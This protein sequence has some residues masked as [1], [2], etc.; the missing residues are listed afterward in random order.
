LAALGL[1]LG[2]L[3]LAAQSAEELVRVGDFGLIDHHG[4][5]HTLSRFAYNKAIVIITQ[6]NRCV[7]NIDLL[8]KY[9]LLRTTWEDRGIEFLMMNSAAEDD[10]ESIRRIAATYDIDFPIMDDH[11]QLVAETLN[12][13]HAGQVLVVDPTTRRL[14]Y[15]GPSVQPSSQSGRRG[16]PDFHAA[17]TDVLRKVVAGTAN[18]AGAATVSIDAGNECALRFP[19]RSARAGGLPDYATDIAPVLMTNC[20]HCH[21]EGGVAPFA[22]N[23]YR[24][25]LGFA[26]MIREVLMT[27]R[28]PPMQVDPHYNRFENASYLSDED[29]QTLVHWVDA[30]APRGDNPV[31]PLA[32]HVKPLETQWQLGPPD[33]IVEVPAFDVPATGVVDYFNHTIDLP[34][35]EHKWVR[36]VQFIP[37]DSRVL[38]HLLAYVTSPE[39]PSGDGPA[40]EDDVR[41][42]LEGYAP[43]KAAATPFPEG[44]GVFIEKGNKLTMQMHYTTIGTPVT[45]R[46]RLGLYFHGEPPQHK[47]LTHSISHWSGGVLQI[48]PGERNHP[49]NH[50]YVVPEDT[51]LYALRPHMHTRGK[52]FR[53]SVVYP[54][55]TTEV[56][57]SVPRYDFNWQPTYRF[58]EPKL[59]PA[60]TRIITDGVFDNSRYHPG[61]PDPTVTAVGGPQS[62]DEMFIG[63]ITYTLPRRDE[64]QRLSAR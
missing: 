49:M 55:G 34:F 12:V 6:A 35:E 11:A 50:N 56:L 38:H 32:E 62:W 19:A 1:T 7:E 21:V 40:S 16:G 27:K 54:D 2:S 36:A 51:M 53:F 60:G 25:V 22:M 14:L 20:T 33:Y 24:M 42:F 43:G 9:K 10:L 30:G 28:M 47:Y 59:L 41:D 46:T 15:R 31:D 52:A 8:P 45:D 13:T 44:T 18:A 37:G 64:V 63:Y 57:M 23:Q 26:P 5:Q 61:N 29:L 17:L 39:T 48:P 58:T 4:T 3:P